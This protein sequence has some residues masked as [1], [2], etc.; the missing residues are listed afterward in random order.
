MGFPWMDIINAVSI[1]KRTEP[2][3]IMNQ[4]VK[5]DRDRQQ[6]Q[7]A[8]GRPSS[9][10]SNSVVRSHP[11]QLP[12]GATGSRFAVLEDYNNDTIEVGHNY[13]GVP[14]LSS[15]SSQS[16][17]E[18]RPPYQNISSRP[19]SGSVS[20]PAPSSAVKDNPPTN[21]SDKLHYYSKPE[22]DYLFNSLISLK[23][24][25]QDVISAMDCFCCNVRSIIQRIQD[26]KYDNFEQEFYSSSSRRDAQGDDLLINL[27]RK[28]VDEL[29]YDFDDV[30]N[31]IAYDMCKDVLSVIDAVEANCHN[32]QQNGKRF[33]KVEDVSS[34][35]SALEYIKPSKD[36]PQ[37]MSQELFISSVKKMNRKTIQSTLRALGLLEEKLSGSATKDLRK[38]LLNV[39]AQRQV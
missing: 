34:R 25:Q 23:F 9:V 27:F 28:M 16:F 39:V 36:R 30:A 5:Y 14:S 32:M 22:D 2:V 24:R 21:T 19:G 10:S 31:A 3:H 29:G 12:S 11:F 15:S 33:M 7:S 26:K 35:T 37:A 13:Q 17:T 8:L 4:C 18:I 38:L 6:T 1:H 20:V